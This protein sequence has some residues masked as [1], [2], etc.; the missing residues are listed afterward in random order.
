MKEF[1]EEAETDLEKET[2]QGVNCR[3]FNSTNFSASLLS[4]DGWK[5]SLRPPGFSHPISG[6]LEY[7]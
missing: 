2:S 1:E 7:I 4:G 5:E 3:V 6:H